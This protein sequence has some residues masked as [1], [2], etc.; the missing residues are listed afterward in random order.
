MKPLEELNMR[1]A[2]IPN[3]TTPILVISE[4]GLRSI[5]ASELLVKKGFYN[6]NNVSGGYRYW[7]K[8]S[9]ETQALSA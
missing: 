4:V 5:K 7:P 8:E 2:E 9:H 1:Y 3:R 6:V